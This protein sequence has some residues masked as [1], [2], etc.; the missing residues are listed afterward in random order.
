MIF[1]SKKKSEAINIMAVDAAQVYKVNADPEAN[2]YYGKA[3][4]SESLFSKW[5]R[6]H[7]TVTNSRGRSRD[8]ISMKFKYNAGDMSTYDLRKRYYEDGATIPWKDY[9]KDGAVKVQ[10]INYRMLYRS[11]G[12]AKEGSCIF[13]RE[14]LHKKY[15]DYLTMGLWDR[16]PDT[17]GAK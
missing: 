15:R 4:I 13:V 16:I 14:S 10:S 11:T 17:P 9:R 7:G 2:L 6:Q 1:I 5:I 12:K 8:F 3:V